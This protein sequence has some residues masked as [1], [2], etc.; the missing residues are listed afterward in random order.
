MERNRIRIAV[1]FSSESMQELSPPNS[2]ALLTLFLSKLLTYGFTRMF[3]SALYCLSQQQRCAFSLLSNK[4]RLNTG[5]LY[6][7]LYLP[8]TKLIINMALSPH[9]PT[10]CSIPTALKREIVTTLL[11]SLSPISQLYKSPGTVISGSFHT[12]IF[13]HIISPISKHQLSC[14]MQRRYS[15][16]IATQFPQHRAF[17]IAQLVKNLPAMQE[18]PG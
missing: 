15:L 18:T 7:I 14:V 11:F 3:R 5:K 17:L 13:N 10:F 16:Q 6:S 1:D 12:I 4:S 2:Q 8:H 9:I